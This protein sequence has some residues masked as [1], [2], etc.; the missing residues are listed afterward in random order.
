MQADSFVFIL[1]K[2]VGT[3]ISKIIVNRKNVEAK[4]HQ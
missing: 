1:L 3:N 2:Y 4:I